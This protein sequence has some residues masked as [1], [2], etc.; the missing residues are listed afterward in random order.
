MQKVLKDCV[1]HKCSVEDPSS[2]NE[3]HRV[4]REGGTRCFANS[5]FPFSI[6]GL[7]VKSSKE[8]E[9]HLETPDDSYIYTGSFECPSCDKKYTFP[10]E[11][12]EHIETS[13]DQS[14]SSFTL[15]LNASSTWKY[16]PCKVCD[17][18]FE[19]EDDV[20]FHMCRVHEYG[21]ECSL[22][23]CE[24]CG[25]RAQDKIS[26]NNHIKEEHGSV[27]VSLMNT[28]LEFGIE[29]LQEVSKR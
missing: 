12:Q 21:E 26:L 4:N 23:T 10:S 16:V 7:N 19:N 5:N 28:L 8:I 29:R 1:Y 14:W 22:Y 27:G 2:E 17:M 18:R 15:L 25:C 9:E 6:C 24:K 13:H 3:N 20:N 11:L